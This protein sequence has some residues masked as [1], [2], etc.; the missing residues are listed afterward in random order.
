[1]MS[2]YEFDI[3]EKARSG[4]RFLND[5]R[6]EIRRALSVEKGKRKLTQQMIAEKLGVHRSVVNRQIMGLENLTAKSI[7][8][9]LW[10]I[11]WEPHFEAREL[12]DQEH[13]ANYSTQLPLPEM[14]RRGSQDSQSGG[15]QQADSVMR[16]LRGLPSNSSPLLGGN[17]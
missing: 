7:G 2:S 8:E 9:L 11:G 13:G 6:D 5:V 16:R 4:S 12:A 10:A 14:L 3:G 15:S 17:S 1:M